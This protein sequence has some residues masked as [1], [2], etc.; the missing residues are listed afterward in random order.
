MRLHEILTQDEFTVVNR[1]FC[2][3]KVHKK[4][5]IVVVDKRIF[6]FHFRICTVRHVR[7]TH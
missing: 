4:L 5:I 7:Q 2:Y 6:A 3:F 1:A